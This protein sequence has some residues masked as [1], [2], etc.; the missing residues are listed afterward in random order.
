MNRT[1]DQA[2]ALLGL[3]PRAFRTRLRELGVLT[4]TGDLASKHRD[5]GHLF[6]DPRSRWNPTLRNYTHYAVVMVKES[7]VEW[8]A[9][10]LNI[11]I[12]NKDAAA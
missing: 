7:G 10:K 5:R 9:K 1:L 11:S 6:S 12:T 2:A 3:K 4:S 8:I